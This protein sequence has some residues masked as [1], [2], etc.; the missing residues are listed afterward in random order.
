M[1]LYVGVHK[2]FGE[3]HF[4]IKQLFAGF[5]GIFIMWFLSTLNPDK[6]FQPIGIGIFTIFILLMGLM[7]FFPV[8]YVV[9]SHGAMRWIKLP[10]GGYIAPVEFF[11]IGFVFFLAWSFSRKIEAGVDKLKEE[12][13]TFLPYIGAFG[14]VVYLIAIMQND[15]G[16]VIVLGSSLVVMAF[17]AGTSTR[18]FILAMLLSIVVFVVAIMTSDHRILRIKLWW[19]SIQNFVLSFLPDSLADALRVQDSIEP[20]QI[21]NSFYAIINGGLFGEGLGNGTI[22]LGFLTEVHTDFVL[23]GIAEEL[24]AV[25]LLFIVFVFFALIFR[26]F[27]IAN[28]LENKMEYLFVLGIGLMIT[29]EFFLNALG[30]TGITPIKGIAVP[31][32][33]YGGSSLLAHS[34]AIGMVLMISKKVKNI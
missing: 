25:G 6:A 23:A 20:Y 31:F 2:E 29:S 22:K 12:V 8:D 27:R 34:F 7:H 1:S 9:F 21:S 19:S 14:V 33:S 17:I 18:F 10:I 26:I 4:L 13:L 30:V 11:K 5:V 28:R 3:Y 32:V 16:Q 15:L 24:G